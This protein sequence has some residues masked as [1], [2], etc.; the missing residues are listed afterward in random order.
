MAARYLSDIKYDSIGRETSLVASQTTTGTTPRLDL[1]Y[2]ANT[3]RLTHLETLPNAGAGAERLKFDYTYDAA[4]N[5]TS[6]A[7]CRRS[8]ET[9]EIWT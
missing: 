3:F 8:P 4:V 1:A 9:E 6:V 5:V 2:D 7:D